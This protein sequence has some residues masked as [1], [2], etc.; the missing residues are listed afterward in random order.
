MCF[1]ILS[2]CLRVIFLNPCPCT[3]YQSNYSEFQMCKMSKDW[4]I[5]NHGLISW[6]IE[7][8]LPLFLIATYKRFWSYFE[9]NYLCRDCKFSVQTSLEFPSIQNFN[10]STNKK[11]RTTQCCIILFII[12]LGNAEY[13][14]GFQSWMHLI[15]NL[16][17]LQVQNI[18]SN[19][20]MF[21]SEIHKD[22]NSN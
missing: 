3:Q 14:Q 15:N 5:P 9:H 19:T 2:W 1:G 17:I 13:Q 8:F 4:A 7:N 6:V 22:W 21:V 12:S 10:L 11:A 20:W 16:Q 18:V